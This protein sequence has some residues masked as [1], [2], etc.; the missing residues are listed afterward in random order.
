[1]KKAGIIILS[2]VL[3]GVVTIFV[4]NA[5]NGA[6]EKA[7]NQE[8][9]EFKDNVKEENED[10]LKDKDT[11]RKKFKPDKSKKGLDMDDELSFS[12][13]AISEGMNYQ[14]IV[15]N[16][17]DEPVTLEFTTSQ[18]YDYEITDKNN[19]VV[20]RFSDGRSF[21]QVL[22]DVTLEPGEEMT[23]DIEL[24]ELEPGDYTLTMYITAR[25]LPHSKQSIEFTVKETE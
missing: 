8:A 12:L 19:E 13:E 22:R 16:T 5:I 25:E 11:L 14:Y 24:P 6:S 15:K 20:Y 23:F 10:I 1:M 3:V 21:M 2:L 9:E 4:V 7:S 17:G 18:Q